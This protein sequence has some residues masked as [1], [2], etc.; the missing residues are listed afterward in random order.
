MHIR[1]SSFASEL[2]KRL[3]VS[4]LDNIMFDEKMIPTAVCGWQYNDT[5]TYT[6]SDRKIE[7]LLQSARPNLWHKWSAF[8][9]ATPI[10]R[11][12][13]MKNDVAIEVAEKWLVTYGCVPMDFL[14]RTMYCANVQSVVW[15]FFSWI[16]E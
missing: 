10:V 6:H 16:N 9:F 1:N 4:A 14:S 11:R 5:Y 3:S 12:I 2:V 15:T 8:R 13:Q 7:K